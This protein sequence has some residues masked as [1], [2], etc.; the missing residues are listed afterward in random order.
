MIRLELE[1]GRHHWEL[2]DALPVPNA[3]RIL[4]TENIAGG[5][6]VIVEPVAAA[7]QYQLELSRDGGTT[8]TKVELQSG[9]GLAVGGLHDGEKVHVRAL[10]LNELHS[11]APGAEY[12]IY[13]TNQPPPPPDGLRVG[14][15]DGA[16]TITWGEIL[17]A[18][19]Y[20]LYAR[21]RTEGESRLLYRG[22]DRSH[23]D[24]RHF[25]R[26]CNSIPGQ[27]AGGAKETV[28]EYCVTAVNGNGES[29]RSY[30]ADTDPTSWRNWDPRPGER[31]RRVTSFANDSP[32]STSEWPRYYPE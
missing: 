9:P 6:R 5:A 8:W 4:R 14:L 23:I 26:A 13:A 3:P 24:R 12:P 1:A 22:M 32:P 17:G 18:S 15:T 29:T 16:A 11:S 31:F 20:R 2:T 25:I 21:L 19:E 10:A 27:S 30:P 28:I 7:T